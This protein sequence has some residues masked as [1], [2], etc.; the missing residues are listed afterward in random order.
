MNYEVSLSDIETEGIR[1]I[2]DLI[3]HV[4]FDEQ[5]AFWEFFL[6]EKKS[7]IEITHIYNGNAGIL[8]TLLEL[9]KINKKKKYADLITSVARRLLYQCKNN[10]NS[11]WS[12]YLG[13]LGIYWV[14]LTTMKQLDIG[15]TKKQ[16]EKLILESLNE[17]EYHPKDELL[18][19][20]AGILHALLFIYVFVN[21][22][23]EESVELVGVDN[24]IITYINIQEYA[25]AFQINM[26]CVF[27]IT[28]KTGKT[29]FQG[30]IKIVD[31][32]K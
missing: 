7:W 31:F 2:E 14:L 20:N 13:N 8:V 21:I 25:F 27:E 15:V 11:I 12:F 1:I 9:Y 16:L 18:Y 5:G 26:L 22:F 10:S 24:D 3:N 28:Q 29:L 32:F 4:K 23:I 17:L 19:G 30:N 6:P